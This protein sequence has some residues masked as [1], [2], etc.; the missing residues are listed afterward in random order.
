MRVC[1]FN[2]C[3]RAKHLFAA[4]RN[5]VVCRQV[6]RFIRDK[7][8]ID[9]TYRQG[10]FSTECQ[11]AI[12]HNTILIIQYHT[13]KPLNNGQYRSPKFRPLF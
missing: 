7:R 9:N 12:E 5:G 3:V 1:R 8:E 13:V 10:A 11:S 4:L 6:C 2:L